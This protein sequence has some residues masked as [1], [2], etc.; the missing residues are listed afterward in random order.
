MRKAALRLA[1]FARE[2]LRQSTLEIH[3]NV[4]SLVV[5]RAGLLRTSY[6]FTPIASHAYSSRSKGGKN[7]KEEESLEKRHLEAKSPSSAANRPANRPARG[8]LAAVNVD[9][10]LERIVMR[11][12]TI[13]VLA[14]I[15]LST[16]TLL[17]LHL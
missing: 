5:S 2:G 12:D 13:E 3:G 8:K 11:V 17:G 7:A 14:L 10:L 15:S 16:L 6:G 4:S 9:A 1:A